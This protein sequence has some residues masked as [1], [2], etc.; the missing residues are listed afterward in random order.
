MQHQLP[1]E[2][3]TVSN[4][5]RDLAAV[6]RQHDAFLHTSEW[7]EPFAATPLEAMACGLPV[8]GTRSGG[9]RELL[10]HGENALTYRPGDCLELA[11]RM[12]ELQ[13]QPALR[14]QMAETA[15]M[16]VIT[17]FNESAVVDQIENYLGTSLEIWQRQ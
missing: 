5:T 17:K 3:L 2:F 11:S 16:E 10:R 15:Q 9:A 13:M 14:C 12:Q 4:Q 1:V 8:V 6:H 7:D